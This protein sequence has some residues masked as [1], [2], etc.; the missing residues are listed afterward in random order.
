MSC[1]AI[2][3][4]TGDGARPGTVPSIPVIGRPGT[5]PWVAVI[6]TLVLAVVAVVLDFGLGNEG[7]PTF[8]VSAAAILGLAWVVGLSTERLGASPGRRSAGSSTR[9]SATSPS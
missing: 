1:G 5:P 9:R 4:M 7:T 8:I 2:G 3:R 6:G